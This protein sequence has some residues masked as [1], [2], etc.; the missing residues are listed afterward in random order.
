MNVEQFLLDNG[1]DCPATRSRITQLQCKY[2]RIRGQLGRKNN[3]LVDS[4]MCTTKCKQ[5]R[6]PKK[7]EIEKFNR[8]RHFKGTKEKYKEVFV[9]R[10]FDEVDISR[11]SSLKRILSEESD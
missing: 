4:L 2:S 1:F 3:N 5:Y 11:G 8:M 10:G 6:S 7:S 9:E